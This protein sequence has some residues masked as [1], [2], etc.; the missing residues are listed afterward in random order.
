[1]RREKEPYRSPYQEMSWKS[2]FDS[3]AYEREKNK[4]LA[5]KK[6]PEE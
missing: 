4:E 6:T 5:K 3:E 1:M 2:G